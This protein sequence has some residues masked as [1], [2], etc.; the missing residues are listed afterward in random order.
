MCVFRNCLFSGILCALYGFVYV[1]APTC[2]CVGQRSVSAVFTVLYLVSETMTSEPV[3]SARP[4][5]LSVST[6]PVL[7]L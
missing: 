1:C 5:D 2:V 6:L 3:I 4:Q 7:G